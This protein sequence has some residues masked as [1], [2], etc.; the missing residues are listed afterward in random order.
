LD[1]L[2]PLFLCHW[3]GKE[4][5]A[6]QVLV[7]LFC[8]GGHSA[9]KKRVAAGGLAKGA[10]GAI[11]RHRPRLGRKGKDLKLNRKGNIGGGNP[12]KQK[13]KKKAQKKAL[14]EQEEARSIQPDDSS[15][16][17]EVSP[18]VAAITGI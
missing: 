1:S 15:R 10:G 13:A 6:L 8:M 18:K 5:E 12:K 2:F 3:I 7:W 11:A 4:T 17:N 14:E 16:L 9:W